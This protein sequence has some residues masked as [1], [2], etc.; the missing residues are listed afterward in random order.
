MVKRMKI[1]QRRVKSLGSREALPKVLADLIISTAVLHR[2][3]VR[4]VLVTMGTQS[5]VNKYS[6]S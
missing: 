3:E 2:G 1:A 6:F 4:K 5:S